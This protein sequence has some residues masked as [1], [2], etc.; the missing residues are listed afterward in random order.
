MSSFPSSRG[1]SGFTLIELLVVIAII[2]ILA[3]ILFP[4]F[5]KAREKARQ[6]SCL[7]NL[8][9]LG[10]AN[11]QYAQDYDEM[12]PGFTQVFISGYSDGVS[13][14]GVTAYSKLMPYV[15]NTQIFTCPSRKPTSYTYSSTGVSQTSS[16]GW[17]WYTYM[18]GVTP[19]YTTLAV[20]VDPA[21]ICLMTEFTNAYHTVYFL[22]LGP[23]NNHGT[24][25]HNDGQNLVYT[26]G[27]AKWQNRQTI[28][29]GFD[30]Y[31]YQQ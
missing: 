21:R 12:L 9:Q 16:Y 6:S 3:A 8:K 22:W 14:N 5:A 18:P 26:D 28:I 15:K 29:G 20:T 30:A 7:S 19:N 23:P 2:A 1:R 11:L 27:H 13:A 24:F 17:N 25:S 10:L 4:V 31:G